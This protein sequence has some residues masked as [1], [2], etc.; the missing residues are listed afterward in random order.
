ML[1]HAHRKLNLLF[2][3]AI[4]FCLAEVCTWAQAPAPA[5]TAAATPPADPTLGITFDIVSIRPTSEG[6]SKI[7][8]PPNGDGLVIEHSTLLEIVRW[9]YN[10]SSLRE[11]QLEGVPTW[12]ATDN[13]EIHAKVADSDV[14]AWQKL[15]D[16]SRRLIFRK[17][18]VDRFKFAWHFADVEAPIYNMVVAKGGLKIKEAGPDEVSPYAFHTAD[19]AIGEDGKRIPYKGA[20]TTWRPSP[21][22]G[23]M[24]VAQQIHMSSFAKNFLSGGIAS[25]PVVDKTGLTGAY[26]FSLDFAPHQGAGPASSDEGPSTSEPA[27]PDLF[28]ALQE[29]LG[30][31]LEPAKG[32]V[33]HLFVD[34]IERPSEN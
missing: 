29:Q 10:M 32:P 2:A 31:K 3:A 25:R 21:A 15:T 4:L 19:G 12:F 27:K 26:N 34:H 24:M 18:L 8:N 7:T 13:Y 9:N 22:G 28:T 11:D 1:K 20:G 30:L 33:S 6:L 23:G 16:G 5:T 14:A 17:V